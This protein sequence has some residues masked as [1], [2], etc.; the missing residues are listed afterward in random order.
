MI[1]T[2]PF[3]PDPVTDC[4][5]CPNCGTWCVPKDDEDGLCF[6]CR[7]AKTY[8]DFDRAM[9]QVKSAT[10]ITDDDVAKLTDIA[11]QFGQE[12]KEGGN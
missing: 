1:N 4:E 5:Q 11:Q 6:N 9:E 3:D 10:D 8:K 7:T 12:L 2:N